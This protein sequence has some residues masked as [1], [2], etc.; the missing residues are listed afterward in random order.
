M[1]GEDKEKIEVFRRETRETVVEGSLSLEGG[2]ISISTGIGFFD[3]MLHLLAFFG[4]WGLI[5]KAKG[6]HQVD[7]HHTVEDVGIVLGEGLYEKIR[8]KTIQRFGWAYVPLNE[9]LG[10]VVVDLCGR[11][12]YEFSGSFPTPFCGDFPVELVP[13]F[14]RSFAMHLRATIHTDL[15]KC[16]NSHHGVEVLFKGLGIALAQALTPSSRLETTKG[17]FG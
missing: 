14:F 3:H 17:V 11:P 12:H 4:R 8:G 6:D 2:D 5:L 16:R 1:V 15:L 9:S 10:R 7:F 13:E